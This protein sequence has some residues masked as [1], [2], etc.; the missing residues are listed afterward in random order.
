MLQCTICVRGRTNSNPIGRLDP[1][2]RVENLV[3][4]AEPVAKLNS[5]MGIFYPHLTLIY[6]STCDCLSKHS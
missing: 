2:E 5:K 3:E 1:V 6:Y 4:R